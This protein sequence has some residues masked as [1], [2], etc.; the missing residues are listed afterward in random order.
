LDAGPP[1]DD[2][3]GTCDW[4]GAAIVELL[5]KEFGVLLKR[6]AVNKLLHRMN[7]SWLCPRPR[8]PQS[9]AAAQDSLKKHRHRSEARRSGPPGRAGAGVAP[10]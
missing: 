4:S 1:P 10:G 2:A 9:D 7:Y 5:D 8:H 3:D 6:D